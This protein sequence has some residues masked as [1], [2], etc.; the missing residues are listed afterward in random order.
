LAWKDDLFSISIPDWTVSSDILNAGT[1]PVKTNQFNQ[2]PDLQSWV[3][4]KVKSVVPETFI[5]E[6]VIGLTPTATKVTLNKA[7]TQR[8]ANLKVDRWNCKKPPF[9]IG[10]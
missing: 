2:W 8:E 10:P 5:T 4:A 3:P 6:G 1:S 9:E 7:L